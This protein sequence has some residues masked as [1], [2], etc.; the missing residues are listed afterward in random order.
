MTKLRVGIALVTHN[1]EA[2][3]PKTLHSIAEQ[4]M[5][6]DALA[7]VD[8]Q[9]TDDTLAIIQS[10]QSPLPELRLASATSDARE[11]KTRIAQNFTQ[12]VGLLSDCDV[13]ALSDHDDVWRSDRLAHQVMIMSEQVD[14][15]MLA[16]NGDIESD[17]A[18]L[19]DTFSVPT[20]FNALPVQEAFRWVLRRSVA[21]G[22]ASMIRP[23]K[24]AQPPDGW[25]HDRW[26][27]LVAAAAGRLRTD[28]Q[29]VIDYRVHGAQQV[30]L[31]PGRQSQRGRSRITSTGMSDLRR[32]LDLRG[33]RSI[34]APACRRELDYSRL[35][36]TLVKG[37]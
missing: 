3:L 17:G 4:T 6:A 13:V 34:A 30:G 36:R 26:W 37:P 28:P 15:W 29:V 35:L 12:A 10:G 8:D 22:G 11:M 21:T 20:G 19:H 1:A 14:V 5:P 23:A 16:S 24:F 7:V 25:L 33:L 2:W 18:S 27:S 32:M 31:D 9:S